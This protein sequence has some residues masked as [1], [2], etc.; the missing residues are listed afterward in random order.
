[1][2]LDKIQ[3]TETLRQAAQILERENERLIAKNLE[4]QRENLR[5]KGED[6][7]ATQLR[8]EELERQ[9]SVLRRKAFGESSEKRDDAGSAPKEK[10]KQTGHGPR[11]QKELPIVEVVHELDAADQ[12]CVACGGKLA[13]W[14]KQFEESEEIDVIERTWVLKKHRRKKY[15][16]GCGQHVE[17]ALGR[18]ALIAGGRYSMNVAIEI[19]VA[20]YLDHNPLER[21]ARAMGREG[22]VIDSQ[23]LWDQIEALARA[24]APAHDRLHDFALTHPA[25]GVDETRWP[26]LGDPEGA[27]RWQAWTI[28]APAA[29]V[30]R[31]HDSRS[32]E[33]AKKVLKN[34][35]GAVM[36]DGYRAYISLQKERGDFTLA[37]CWAHVRRKF[38]ELEEF[39]PGQAREFLELIRELYEVEASCPTG[40]PGDELRARLRNERSRKIVARIQEK[41]I[42]TRALRESPLGRASTYAMELWGGLVRFLDD[43]KIPID[44]NAAERAMRGPVIGRK[45]H[46]GSRSKRGTE[47]AALFYSLLESAKL[48][49]VDPREYLRQAARAAIRS[50]K[51][52][53]PHELA[54]A[55]LDSAA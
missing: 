9:L 46:Y 1:M 49:E 19:A 51:I 4:L 41:L 25:I 43:P 6:P 44:N 33:A 38:I 23:T 16:C 42:E 15:R 7:G 40:P 35:R 30:Y 24:L 45:N 3:D 14:P 13:E 53:L 17:T 5:L 26:L 20:K 36:A 21:Q 2:R 18:E 52:P 11:E 50:E 12:T 10:Q 27:K 8:I 22:L 37:H 48:N 31:I 54:T 55:K 29:V 39:T 28:A 34:Y 32:T 47:V